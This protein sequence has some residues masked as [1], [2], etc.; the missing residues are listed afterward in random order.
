MSPLSFLL[1]FLY[2]NSQTDCFCLLSLLLLL[3]GFPPA[4]LIN[5]LGCLRGN[6]NSTCARTNFLS[7]L[8]KASHPCSP[9]VRTPWRSVT[10]SSFTFPS[11]RQKDCS[12]YFPSVCPSVLPSCDAS[13]TQAFMSQQ[14]PHWPLFLAHLLYPVHFLDYCLCGLSEACA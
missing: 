1:W 9:Q 14:L 13:L 7:F 12:L 2:C 3:A 5:P 4:F 6:L 8:L 10:L 11:G